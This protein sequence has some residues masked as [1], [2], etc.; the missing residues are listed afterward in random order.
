VTLLRRKY[1]FYSLSLASGILAAFVVAIDVWIN[2]TAIHDPHIFGVSLF[3]VGVIVHII[4][5]IALNT[6]IGKDMVLGEFLDP[7]FRGIIIPRGKLLKYMIIAGV[8][9][10]IS[11]MSYFFIISEVPD[12]SAIMP[13]T[14]LVTAY[15]VIGDLVTEKEKPS[16]VEIHSIF[17]IIFGAFLVT[18]SKGTIDPLGLLLVLGPMNMGTFIYIYA[19]KRARM[20]KIDEYHFDSVN[21]RVWSL[22]FTAIL[23]TTIMP[24]MIPL[25]QIVN[26]CYVAIT[27]FPLLAFDMIV[28]FLSYV[29]YI[30]ALGLGK[31]SVVNALYSI[32][33]V[34]GLPI[35]IILASLF[36]GVFL[37]PELTGVFG[38]I[39]VIGIIFVFL[40]MIALSLSEVTAYVFIKAKPRE[41]QELI[42]NLLKIKGVEYISVTAG[43]YDY[44]LR[45]KLRSLGK[46][47]DNIVRELSRI[48]GISDFIWVSVLKEWERI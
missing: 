36:P 9:N 44:I 31:M 32:S 12:P 47:Y 25:G 18:L 40:G 45:V 7:S 23:F 2:T 1:L 13:F 48:D 20:I 33:V 29:L 35:T 11:S 6:K 17:M 26:A 10:A 19:Q 4:L 5:L 24:F 15:L 3:I 42:R 41:T 27:Y 39:K 8:G 38:V 28:T 16:V 37:F 46:A 30:R 21:L 34:V 14:N 43:R 22:I